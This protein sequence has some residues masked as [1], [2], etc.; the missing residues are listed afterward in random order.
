ML[1]ASRS[2]FAASLN[3][4]SCHQIFFVCGQWPK[5]REITW[6]FSCFFF[7][8]L[9]NLLCCMKSKHFSA[10]FLK[11]KLFILVNW[12]L[13]YGLQPWAPKPLP[14]MI[15]VCFKRSPTFSTAIKTRQKTFR[16]QEWECINQHLVGVD[17]G[18]TTTYCLVWVAKIGKDPRLILPS[19][20]SVTRFGEISP[21]GQNFKRLW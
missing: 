19:L 17:G 1:V 11:T 13:L 3:E 16:Q 8:T 9:S 15:F 7:W 2:R 4:P 6:D 21:L 18:G 10:R 14:I 12:F 20:D 5:N